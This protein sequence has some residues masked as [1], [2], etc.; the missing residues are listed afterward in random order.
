MDISRGL[1]FLTDVKFGAVLSHVHVPSLVVHTK[2]GYSG[3]G[4]VSFVG[5]CSVSRVDVK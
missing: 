1:C 5:F 3:V 2:L 4:M